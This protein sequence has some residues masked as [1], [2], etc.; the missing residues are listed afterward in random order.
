MRQIKIHSPA[1]DILGLPMPYILGQFF[2]NE[3]YAMPLL[4]K[5]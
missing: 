3:F 4:D 5:I 2:T 1:Q